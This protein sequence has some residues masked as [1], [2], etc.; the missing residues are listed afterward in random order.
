ML[1][2][3][4]H[5]G[6]EYVPERLLSEWA[7]RDPVLRYRDKLRELGVLETE[8]VAIDEECRA[9]VDDAVDYAEVSP[10]PDPAAVA[11]GVFAE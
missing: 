3:A 9:V 10:L 1:G 8:L 4:V 2:H 5:D 7:E 11:D 6:A